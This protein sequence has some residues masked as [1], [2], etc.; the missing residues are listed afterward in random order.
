MIPVGYLHTHTHTLLKNKPSSDTPCFST[1]P[2]LIS[3]TVFNSFCR[4]AKYL[5]PSQELWLC[6]FVCVS[7]LCTDRA[8][9]SAASQ[10]RHTQTELLFG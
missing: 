10:P 8:G 2:G 9:F 3:K 6:V 4:A 1:K 5:I 7:T